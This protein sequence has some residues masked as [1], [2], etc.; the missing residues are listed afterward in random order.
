[1]LL[2]KILRDPDDITRA[3]YI[4]FRQSDAQINNVGFTYG[5]NLQKI[6]RSVESGE[7]ASKIFVEPID[8]SALENG[9]CAI[10]SP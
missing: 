7:I 8:N 9:I 1:M 5:V 6:N 10:Q 2:V 3:Q 4:T